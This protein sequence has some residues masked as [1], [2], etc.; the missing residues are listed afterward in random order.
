MS[1]YSYDQVDLPLLFCLAPMS[2]HG[3]VKASADVIPRGSV[4]L[5]LNA[6]GTHVLTALV[7]EGVR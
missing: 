2:Q 5:G 3:G 4:D 6:H 1:A 7:C